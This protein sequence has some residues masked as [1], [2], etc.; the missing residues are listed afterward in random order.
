MIGTM[1]C[2]SVFAINNNT[3]KLL[4]KDRK[5]VSYTGCIKKNAPPSL[6][7]ISATKYLIFKLFFLLKIE[8]N[9]QIFSTKPFLC[10]FWGLR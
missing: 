2:P 4:L 5:N 7:D 1:C 6:L 9:M 3:F 10:D 8:I